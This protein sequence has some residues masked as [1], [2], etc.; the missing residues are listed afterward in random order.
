MLSL[1]YFKPGKLPDYFFYTFLT[2]VY[3]CENRHRT[4]EADLN[5]CWVLV[6]F[7]LPMCL[8]AQR[9][10]A[11]HSRMSLLLYKADCS[12]TYHSTLHAPRVTPCSALSTSLP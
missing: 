8:D 1:K 4:L 9:R 6:C 3:S 7:S 10:G 2:Y 12:T 11:G 5:V